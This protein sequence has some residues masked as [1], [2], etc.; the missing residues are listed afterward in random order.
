MRRRQLMGIAAVCLSQFGTSFANAEIIVRNLANV[1]VGGQWQ[2]T[3]DDTYAIQPGVY[4]LDINRDGQADLKLEHGY[5]RPP[6]YVSHQAAQQLDAALQGITEIGN[7]L[8]KIRNIAIQ[9]ANAGVNDE[10]DFE[11]GQTAVDSY[12]NYINRISQM[13]FAGQ[14]TLGGDAGFTAYASDPNVMQILK[15]ANTTALGN[16]VALVDTA[17]ERAYVSAGTAAS[18]SL[19]QDEILS[20]N[21][22]N[23]Q[24]FDGMGQEN[25][26]DRINEYTKL[27]GVRAY[28]NGGVTNLLS[29]LWGSEGDIQ[30]ISN[31]QPD[32]TT[33]GFV[34]WADFDN[35]EDA[36]LIV[37]G[38]SYRGNGDTVTVNAGLAKG[39]TL[40]LNEDNSDP[41]TTAPAGA[42]TTV[43]VVD[44]S[45]TYALFPVG[46][47][48]TI[49]V[50]YP[51]LHSSAL[52]LQVANNQFAA[53]DRIDITNAV[54]SQDALAII[55]KAADEIQTYATQFSL[56]K[57]LYASPSGQAFVSSLG[58]S[59]ESEIAV[60]LQPLAEGT[61]LDDRFQFTE[62]PLELAADKL[63]ALGQF[64]GF[65][66]F[67]GI[68]SHYGW[69]RY[70]L[71][72]ERRM[73]LKQVVYES[74]PGR[75]I[76]IGYVPEPA[77]SLA[78][79]TGIGFALA[80]LRTPRIRRSR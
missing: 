7:S 42:Q 59:G 22:V 74:E 77:N 28:D 72:D 62:G 27:T 3:D 26:I 5:R 18:T 1:V 35:G 9:T 76:R 70:S 45:P 52:G 41:A 30:V 67:D 36:A 8:S 4:Q 12:L 54:K 80:A 46:Q 69:L 14:R 79:L 65:R 25:V 51:T 43:T 50:S 21:G 58:V 11:A 24:L 38:L 34:N 57:E 63:S 68:Q 23:V 73:T 60:E 48:Q 39:L 15:V 75:G 19:G 61:L 47:D 10:D 29:N 66:F 53:L 37:N 55:D 31:Q 16:Y 49:T 17:G 71:D 40:R 2:I 32:G 64:V 44:N 6:L 33:S 56:I 78:L 13:T 20:I